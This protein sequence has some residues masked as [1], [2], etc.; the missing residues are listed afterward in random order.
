MGGAA[1]A[2]AALSLSPAIDADYRR[3]AERAGGLAGLREGSIALRRSRRCL[4]AHAGLPR[5]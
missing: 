1:L 2:A 3:F 5:C 4:I